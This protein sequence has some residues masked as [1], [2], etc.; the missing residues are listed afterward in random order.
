M[1]MFKSMNVPTG[2]SW[3]TAGTSE[4]PVDGISRVDKCIKRHMVFRRAF[5]QMALE[6]VGSNCRGNNLA[7]RL[8]A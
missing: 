8:S 6:P 4:I 2:G 7:I 3:V 1:I 5:R